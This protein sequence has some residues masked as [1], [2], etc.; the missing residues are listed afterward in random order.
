MRPGED[1]YPMVKKA[2]SFLVQAGPVTQQER[3]EEDGGY[4]PATLAVCI[5][6]L[7]M[8]A[9]LAR[10][11]NDLAV[12]NYAEAVADYWQANLDRW[13]F[14]DHGAIDPRF[15]RHYIR[16][17]ASTPESPDGTVQN[18]WVPIKNLPVGVPNLYPE[19][20]VIDGGFLELVR[21]G[22]KAP[23]DPHVV[24]SVRAYDGILRKDLPYGPLYYRYNHDG[25]GEQADGSP[26]RGA[27]I[28]R[29]WP[30]LAGERGHYAL[31]AGDNAWP[32]LTAMEKAAS[33]GGLIP[34]QVWDGPDIPAREL[35][36][37][38]PSGSAMPLVWAHAE[39]VKLLHSLTIGEVFETQSLVARRYAQNTARPTCHRLFWQFNHKRRVWFDHETTLRIAVAAP[40]QLV[41]TTDDW[42]HHQTVTMIDSG[43]GM[44]YYDIDLS[45]AKAAEFTFYWT[46]AGHWEGQNFRL[47]AAPSP[48]AAAGS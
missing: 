37:G 4:S 25:Y 36:Y 18:G 21:Y 28:G 13:T 22:V 46:A 32:Y 10:E 17:H 5:S 43:L 19:V 3:W 8:G 1:V 24:D 27:G 42:Q 7:I 30:L 34:E 41:Y 15:P 35:Y 38:R 47:Q 23:L 26:Y 48:Q 40:A 39:Y 31:A 16:I 2:L 12:A 20:A 45:Q 44:F 33:E 29:L 11:R 14:T 9:A 6:A